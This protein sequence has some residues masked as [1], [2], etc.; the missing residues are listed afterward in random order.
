MLAQGHVDDAGG[1]G[2]GPAG[3][4]V[5]APGLSPVCPFSVLHHLQDTRELTSLS[6][7]LK[8][9]TTFVQFSVSL[10]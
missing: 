8:K 10:L 3:L 1:Q 6:G 7:L 5:Q 4:G 2:P 9:A